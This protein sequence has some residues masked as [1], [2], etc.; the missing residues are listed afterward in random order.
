[1]AF[2]MVMNDHHGDGRFCDLVRCA[3]GNATDARRCRSG[4]V[5]RPLVRRAS[6]V[7]R[8]PPRPWPR[9]GRVG[10][11]R[12]GRP[13]GAHMSRPVIG[14]TTSARR[15][16]GGIWDTEAAL[17]PAA[18]VSAMEE[19]GGRPPLIPPSE[20]GVEETLAAVGGLVFSGGSDLDPELYEQEPHDETL[21]IAS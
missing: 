10:R 14:I 21:G 2:L 1:K 19:A 5:L 7:A 4:Q 6:R 3:R 12:R 8:R 11:P 15:A 16:R 17:A 9:L 13:R 18:Y 20:D